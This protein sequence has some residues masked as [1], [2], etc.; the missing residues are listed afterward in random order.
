[1]KKYIIKILIFVSLINVAGM[2]SKDDATPV[3]VSVDPTPVI[4]TVN[5]GTWHVTLYQESGVDKL[6]N[7]TGYNFTFSPSGVLTATNDA[8]TYNGTWSVTSDNSGDDSPSSDLD[9]NIAFS[10]PSSFASLTED[11]NILE[12]TATKVKLVH[13]SGGNGGADYINFEKN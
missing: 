10:N 1:M 7:F 3:V 12:Y 4:N 2:C 5:N 9:F 13:V 11:W 8:N 6:A